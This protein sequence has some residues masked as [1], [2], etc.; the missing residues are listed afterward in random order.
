MSKQL[1]SVEKITAEA[2]DR[3]LEAWE[4]LRREFL[5]ET[6]ANIKQLLW[7]L[8]NFK[9]QA[10]AQDRIHVQKRPEL[11]NRGTH[12]FLNCTCCLRIRPN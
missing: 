10:Y 5:W 2:N 7:I 12:I 11:K 6:R 8:G 3:M 1:P 9:N 4:K